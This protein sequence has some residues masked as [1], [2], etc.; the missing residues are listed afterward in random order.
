MA[1]TVNL[2][3]LIYTSK[4]GT[5]IVYQSSKQLRQSQHKSY[6]RE[7]KQ[8]IKATN[9]PIKNIVAK[10][11]LEMIGRRRR[12]GNNTRQKTIQ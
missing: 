6:N 12:Q 7:R 3:L 1:L 9:W 8:A 4:P 5:E 10:H 11:Q 2:L